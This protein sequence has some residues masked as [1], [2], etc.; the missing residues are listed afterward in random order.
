MAPHHL[1][2]LARSSTFLARLREKVLVFGGAMGTGIQSYNLTPDDFGGLDG[3]NEYLC[4]TRP[5]II[6]ELHR[7][8]FAAGADVVI[9]NSFGSSSIVLAEYGLADQT[10]EL[11]RSSA[12]LAREVADDFSAGSWPRFVAGASS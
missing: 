7:R 3:C 5:Q 8:H 12:A 10:Y 11:S 9:T 6:Q 2:E 1:D 4:H